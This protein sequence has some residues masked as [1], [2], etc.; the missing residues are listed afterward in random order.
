MRKNINMNSDGLKS[1][2]YYCFI[3]ADMALNLIN[4]INIYKQLFILNQN[5]YSSF[6]YYMYLDFINAKSLNYLR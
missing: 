2:L 6:L 5:N 4:Q 3:I 1:S